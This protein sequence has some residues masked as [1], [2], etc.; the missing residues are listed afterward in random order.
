MLR[1]MNKPSE[2]PS[3]GAFTFLFFTTTLSDWTTVYT[4]TFYT[5]TLQVKIFGLIVTPQNLKNSMETPTLGETATIIW[6]IVL[7]QPAALGC[8][9][10]LFGEK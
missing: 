7:R 9:N 1:S 3:K 2:N 5:S 8:G 4:T 6:R 10:L